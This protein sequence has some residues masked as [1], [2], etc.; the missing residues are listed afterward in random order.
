MS[1]GPLSLLPYIPRSLRSRS[2]MIKTRL[3]KRFWASL[4]V[5]ALLVASV[6]LCACLFYAHLSWKRGNR[7][8]AFYGVVTDDQ[9]KPIAGAQVSVV[10]CRRK[11]F[12]I[13][14]PFTN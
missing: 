9:G 1:A 14:V 4:A 10:V 3:S 8:I 5:I 13:P 7:P 11:V 2:L 6:V 12:P